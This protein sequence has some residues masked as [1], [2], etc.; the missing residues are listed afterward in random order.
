MHESFIG[1]IEMTKSGPQ[2]NLAGPQYSYL[3]SY[4]IDLSLTSLLAE[5]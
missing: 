5:V 4:P 2:I 3:I 1:Q